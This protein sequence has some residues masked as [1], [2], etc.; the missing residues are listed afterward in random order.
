MIIKRNI[1]IFIYLLSGLSN[2]LFSEEFYPFKDDVNGVS[3]RFDETSQV[4][5]NINDIKDSFFVSYENISLA[6][7]LFYKYIREHELKKAAILF[8][9]ILDISCQDTKPEYKEKCERYKNKTIFL[10][11]EL[12]K[13]KTTEWSKE[14]ENNQYSLTFSSNKYIFKDDVFKLMILFD[15][16]VNLILKKKTKSKTSQIRQFEYKSIQSVGKIFLEGYQ[17]PV[18]FDLKSYKNLW[19]NRASLSNKLKWN[20]FEMEYLDGKKFKGLSSVEPKI[21]TVY[22]IA[23]FND[24]GII[25][26]FQG[27]VPK[28]VFY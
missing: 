27:K 14:K 10:E 6:V 15:S 19:E 13:K 26:S 21:K 12:Y 1:F 9:S 24:K 20:D 8:Y 23:L 25:M 17:K 7:N 3:Y 22:Y 28:L 16:R 5:I 2:Y 18:H 11:K 4:D